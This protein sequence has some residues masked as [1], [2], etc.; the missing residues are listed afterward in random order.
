MFSLRRG[1]PRCGGT[2]E[3][4]DDAYLRSLVVL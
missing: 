3:R 1:I 4:E 2:V